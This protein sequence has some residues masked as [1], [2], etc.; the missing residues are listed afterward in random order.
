MFSQIFTSVK[1]FLTFQPHKSA[2]SVV[3]LLNIKVI[4][5]DF[6]ILIINVPHN[7]I[8]IYFKRII[9]DNIEMN[10][11]DLIIE[12]KLIRV[13]TRKV[14]TDSEYFDRLNVK[15]NE[16][17]ILTFCRKS[18]TNLELLPENLTGPADSEIHAK[19]FH[20]RNSHLKPVYRIEWLLGRDDMRK[21][22]ITLAQ[23]CAYI[24][25]LQPFSNKLIKFYRQKIHNCIKHKESA[26]N[27][28]CQ[29][30]FPADKVTY[31]LRLKANN[32]KLALDWLIDNV[33]HQEAVAR[34]SK[35]PRASLISS[36][37]RNS[38]LSSKFTSA[39]TINERID[40]LL[41]IVKFYSEKDEPVYMNYLKI[42]IFMG[43]DVDEAREALRI[44]RNNIGAAC[45]YLAKDESPSVM[46]LRNGISTSSLIH[47]KLIESPKVQWLLSFPETFIYLVNYLD[48][49]FYEWETSAHN[50]IEYMQ[51]IIQL[52]HEE[53]H[54]LAVN[55]FNNS[56]I[57]ISAVSAPA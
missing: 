41:E 5:K 17:F 49:G 51:Y 55:Q 7:E 47:K 35:S 1:N 29:L 14:L 22:Y 50:N 4:S 33:K 38:I 57:P 10:D 24:I 40:G 45:D 32:H 54:S 53:K 34:S 30:G 23:E 13:K 6:G 2:S 19:T 15:T 27:V 8:V 21:I 20:L 43:Y 18:Y 36:N 12:M 42:M 39:S 26:F 44:V 9:L 25:G 52:Y 56:L 16:E 37:R 46:E 3:K 11:D 28:M 31:A 48:T